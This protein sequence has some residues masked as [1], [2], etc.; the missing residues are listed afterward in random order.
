LQSADVDVDEM[1]NDDGQSFRQ[2][3]RSKASV[4]DSRGSKSS[5]AEPGPMRA[6][7]H[8]GRESKSSG[9]SKT[10]FGG[11]KTSFGGSKTSFGGSKTSFGGSKT[12][13]GGSKTSFDSS[14][15]VRP[16]LVVDDNKV[17]FFKLLFR[18]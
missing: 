3:V 16:R 14:L 6:S 8:S 2:S 18:H 12:S 9:G 10:S 5:F 11:S 13:F 4:R 1:G 15:S 7:M 17:C